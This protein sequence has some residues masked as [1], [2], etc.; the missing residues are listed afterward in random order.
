M[1]EK[2][3]IIFFILLGISFLNSLLFSETH[4][5]MNWVYALSPL[6]IGILFFIVTEVM[7]SKRHYHCG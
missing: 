5:I 4:I 7:G 2:N 6:I 1:S 3:I